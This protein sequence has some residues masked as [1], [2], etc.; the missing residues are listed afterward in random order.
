MLDVAPQLIGDNASRLSYFAGT[1]VPSSTAVNVIFAVV[2]FCGVMVRLFTVPG[3]PT[4]GGG[5][6]LGGVGDG[7]GDGGGGLITPPL[8]A[9]IRM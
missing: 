6:G 8:G 9:L 1:P 5:V 2:V 4:G 3:A 7:D